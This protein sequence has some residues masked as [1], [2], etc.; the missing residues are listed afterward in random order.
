MNAKAEVDRLIQLWD[1]FK[2]LMKQSVSENT[3][4][5]FKQISSEVD[6]IIKSFSSFDE[7]FGQALLGVSQIV[8]SINNIAIAISE[9]VSTVGDGLKTAGASTGN[10]WLAI[11]GAVVEIVGTIWTAVEQSNK[12][13]REENNRKLQSV[14]DYY[15]AQIYGELSYQALVRRRKSEEAYG[16]SVS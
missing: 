1:R 3:V 11:I 14:K 4:D 9:V 8:K 15:D 6:N 13:L 5:S 12:K 10:A 7:G 16:L 2:K